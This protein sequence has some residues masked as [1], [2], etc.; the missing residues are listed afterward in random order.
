MYRKLS[1]QTPPT[2]VYSCEHDRE[3]I[4]QIYAV[5]TRNSR[6]T[7]IYCKWALRCSFGTRLSITK[8]QDL[9]NN[10]AKEG[11]I[12]RQLHFFL[13]ESTGTQ[14]TTSAHP[15]KN[16][17]QKKPADPPALID[18]IFLCR[19]TP[20]IVWRTDWQYEWVDRV[21]PF[22]QKKQRSW[23]EKLKKRCEYKKVITP[24]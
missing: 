21:I 1:F 24:R 2:H 12:N 6:N 7:C 3:T 20:E 14:K 4:I 15:K 10:A 13:F 22:H 17:K 8:T 5:C 19:P 23:K 9:I 11:E 16:W 18:L